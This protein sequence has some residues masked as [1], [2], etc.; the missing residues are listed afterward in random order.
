MSTRKV[1][2]SKKRQV[3]SDPI[4]ADPICPISE[5]RSVLFS[6][7]DPRGRAAA[8]LIR[9]IAWPALAALADSKNNDDDNNNDNSN[10][11]NNYNIA[12]I[13]KLIIIILLIAMITLII[14][15]I[16]I[17]IRRAPA[18]PSRLP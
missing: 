2:L 14:I 11:D 12:I 13:T 18:Y 7:A 16:K 6:S 3:C 9:P 8:Y 17:I 10:H 15:K 4:S 5:N 1:P